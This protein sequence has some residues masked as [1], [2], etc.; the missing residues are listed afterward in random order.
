MLVIIGADE[1]GNTDVP[2]L[3]APSVI[4]GAM[5]RTAF[6]TCIET[7]L[8][9]ALEPGTVVILDNLATHKSPRAVA[10]LK[11]RRCWML[12]LP[13][14]SPDPCVAKNSPPDCFLY[15]PHRSKR[16]EEHTSELQSL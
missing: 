13:A 7:L 15:A 10:A 16:S 11:E 6:D 3:I 2:G 8:A 14:C 4:A 5:D 12:F 1:W 9:P